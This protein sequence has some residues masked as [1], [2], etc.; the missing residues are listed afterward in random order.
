MFKLT[1]GSDIPL[2]VEVAT[3]HIIN[4]RW[5]NQKANQFN[6]KVEGLEYVTFLYF[7][8]KNKQTNLWLNKLALLSHKL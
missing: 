4:K 7:K 3:L 6:L 1:K 5:K 8:T 2:E